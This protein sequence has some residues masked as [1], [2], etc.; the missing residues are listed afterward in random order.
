MLVLIMLAGIGFFYGNF[1]NIGLFLADNGSGNLTLCPTALQC[2]TLS[3]QITLMIPILAYRVAAPRPT[4]STSNAYINQD[5]DL[6]VIELHSLELRPLQTNHRVRPQ[7]HA[8]LHAAGERGGSN[9]SH[10][11]LR[12]AGLLQKGSLLL[13]LY[14]FRFDAGF[15]FL[16][17]QGD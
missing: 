15:C 17:A 16:S 7:P 6:R 11:P 12:S 13:H 3:T 8:A 4:T 2:T 1:S 14:V 10:I 5:A 9:R